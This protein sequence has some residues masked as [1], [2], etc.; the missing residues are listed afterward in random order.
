MSIYRITDK[1]LRPVRESTFQSEGLFERRDLQSLIR[2]T[3]EIVDPNLM[4]LAEE[5]G[6]WE[7]SRRRIDLLCIDKEARIVVLELKR[8]EDGGHMDLQAIRYAAMVSSMTFA[9]AVEAHKHFLEK[10]ESDADGAEESILKFLNW[11]EPQEEAFGNDVRL[12]LASAEFAKEVMTT[13]I[14]LNKHDIDITCIRIKP[15]RL[16]NE[17][18]LHVEQIFPLPEAADYQVRIR[19]KERRERQARESNR[20]L[21]RYNLFNGDK[22]HSGLPKLRLAHAVIAEAVKR[23]AAPREVLKKKNVWIAVDGELDCEAFLGVADLERDAQSPDMDLKHFLTGE[24]ELIYH[25]GKTYA[26]RGNIWGPNTLPELNQ[27]IDEFSLSD[28]S[29]Q[30]AS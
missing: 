12:I 21:T 2:D 9:A 26:L 30:A 25:G 19:D 15:Y 23:G 11:S 24:G 17:I 6:G 14:W 29:F 7:D 5:F 27:I 3:I 8:T 1:S 28:V 10:Q 20:D 16:E 22:R 18:L 4:V 13:V